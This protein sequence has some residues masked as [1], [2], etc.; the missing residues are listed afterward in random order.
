MNALT[1]TTANQSTELSVGG[2]YDPFA[3]AAKDMGARAAGAFL[4]FSGNSGEWTFG[5]A[6]DPSVIDHGSQFVLDFTKME[7][8]FICWKSGES[9]DEVTVNLMQGNPPAIESLKDH[10]PYETY[11]DGTEDGW[12]DIVK[13]PF[14]LLDLED[15]SVASPGK[16]FNYNAS[17]KSARQALANLLADYA[18]VYRQHQNKFP[19][20]EIGAAGFISKKNKKAGKKYAPTMR[21]KGW[22]SAAEFQALQNAGA[23]SEAPDGDEAEGVASEADDPKNYP[24]AG[25]E[26]PAPAPESAP[27]VKDAVVVEQTPASTPAP[28]ARQRNRF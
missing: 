24:P 1:N 20:I 8:G 10:G 6:E 4:K 12:T 23:E 27:P 17:S 11:Q 15:E 25:I 22:I 9:V 26:A 2:G 18:N 7:R 21:I 19:V 28:S 16:L 5:S 3:Q 13:Q 14:V